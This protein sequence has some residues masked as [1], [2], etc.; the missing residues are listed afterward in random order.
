MEKNDT[1]RLSVPQSQRLAA[2]AATQAKS[3]AE[4]ERMSLEVQLRQW[5]VERA[6][7]AITG[8]DPKGTGPVSEV[9][10]DIFTFVYEPIANKE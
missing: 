3:V 10:S 8:A 2:L 1:P 9:A 7:E 6:I 4:I 5:S